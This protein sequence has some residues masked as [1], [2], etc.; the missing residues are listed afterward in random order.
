MLLLETIGMGAIICAHYCIFSWCYNIS[1]CRY[2][3]LD[4]LLK[5]LP[6]IIGIKQFI[7]YMDFSETTYSMVVG[8]IEAV[9]VVCIGVVVFL[10]SPF[11]L[12]RRDDKEIGWIH[13]AFRLLANCALCAMPLAMFWVSNNIK[14]M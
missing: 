14:I 13:L 7:D 11:S 4:N 9:Y 12:I 2:M 3:L 10:C 8:G 5:K 6:R 1:N